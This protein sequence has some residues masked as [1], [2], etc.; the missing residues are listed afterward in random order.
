MRWSPLLALPLLA[1]AVPAAAHPH[2]WITARAEVLYAADGRVEGVRHAWSFDPGYS[3]FVT[4]GLDANN[5]GVL[6]PSELQELAK[7]N[8][9]S[10]VDFGYFTVMKVG[11]RKQEFGSPRDYGMSFDKGV[12]TLTFVLPLKAPAS[13]KTVGLE[14]YDPTFF[15][16]FRFAEGDRAVTLAQAPQ[17]C[18]VTVSRPKP[19]DESQAKSLS[20][21][22]FEAL[23]ANSNFGASFATRALVAC[24]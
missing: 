16:D 21:S 14:V 13:N 6:E 5:N 1:L 10:L 18:Q 4:Q 20:E 19:I 9:E 12:A 7:V 2:V 24:P 3:A 23:T 15:V 8:T 11:G 22:F 17:G